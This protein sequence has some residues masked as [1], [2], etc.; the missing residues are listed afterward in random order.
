MP[1]KELTEAESAMVLALEVQGHLVLLRRGMPG[2]GKSPS[3][4]IFIIPKTEEKCSL[5]F[6]C[7]LGN[8]K[9]EGPNPHMRPP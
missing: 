2:Y 3:A 6:N 9:F 5:I 1:C 8:K 4:P 7:Q